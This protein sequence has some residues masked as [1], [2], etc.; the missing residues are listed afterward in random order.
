MKLRV[1]CWHMYQGQFHESY[2]SPLDDEGN[3]L[4]VWSELSLRGNAGADLKL[5]KDYCI[6]SEILCGGLTN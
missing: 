4:K 3:V 2:R 5:P 6:M 1:L